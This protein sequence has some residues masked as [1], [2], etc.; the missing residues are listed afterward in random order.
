[1]CPQRGILGEMCSACQN[2]TKDIRHVAP[3]YSIPLKAKRSQFHLTQKP[4]P[5]KEEHG[6]VLM[7]R[8][9]LYHPDIADVKKLS[10]KVEKMTSVREKY[11]EWTLPALPYSVKELRNKDLW[12]ADSGASTHL[13]FD[14][15]AM[16]NKRKNNV[17]VIMGNG[18]SAKSQIVG[19]VKGL[20][21]NV[22]DKKGFCATLQ[23]VAHA[24][25]AK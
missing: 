13:T 5:I 22:N 2:P 21:C 9:M 11:E 25:E 20:I 15:T 4:A 6:S 3:T 19:D 10:S 14:D 7:P 23:N 16:I 17:K 24:P 1:M 18:T 12:I 8:A